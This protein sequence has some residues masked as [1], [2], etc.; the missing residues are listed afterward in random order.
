MGI[1]C[2]A[3][4]MGTHNGPGYDW[5]A[6]CSLFMLYRKS[7][8]TFFNAV[9]FTA[10]YIGLDFDMPC[11]DIVYRPI[12]KIAYVICCLSGYSEWA[13]QAFSHINGTTAE[14]PICIFLLLYTLWLT[15]VPIVC[16][17]KFKSILPLFRNSKRAL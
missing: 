15:I 9:L 6:A 5:A 13:I 3:F 4:C 2:L 16:S 8:W 12:I 14:M 10:M 1:I 7:R 11:D 17:W